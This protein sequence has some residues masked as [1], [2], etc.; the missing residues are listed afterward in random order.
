MDQLEKVDKLRERAN[1]SYEEAKEA[2]EAS[3]WDLLDA[4]VYLEKHGKAEPP[5]QETASSA[6]Q[7]TP[8]Y[9]S[10]KEKVE[11]QEKES[12]EGLLTKLAK[13]CKVLFRMSKENSFC[14]NRH[15]KELIRI[16][17]WVL[18]LAL[19]FAWKIILPAMVIA[20]FF[21]CRYS[22]S[23]KDDL[24]PANKA[25]DKASEFAGKVKSEFESR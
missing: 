20:L 16:P 13:I 7:E 12:S 8:Q 24:S 9:V 19:L 23:G 15:E 3:N 22:F 14:V 25:M 11:E 10:V 2:L 5:E 4:M 1:V 18:I 17:A 21:D 6:S